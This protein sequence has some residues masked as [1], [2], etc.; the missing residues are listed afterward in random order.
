MKITIKN[1]NLIYTK[2]KELYLNEQSKRVLPNGGLCWA[3]KQ[4][5]KDLGYIFSSVCDSDFHNSFPELMKLKPKNS[6]KNDF[7]WPLKSKRLR[8]NRFDTMIEQTSEK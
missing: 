2:A 5:A 7:W 4:T 3:I 6:G 1:R 8:L